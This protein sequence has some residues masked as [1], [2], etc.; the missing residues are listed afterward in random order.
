MTATSTEARKI[1]TAAVRRAGQTVKQATAWIAPAWTEHRHGRNDAALQW[2]DG[3]REEANNAL[4]LI[5]GI[6]T[7]AATKHRNAAFDILENVGAIYAAVAQ[8]ADPVVQ[9]PVEGATPTE[10]P[11]P[12]REAVPVDAEVS[13]DLAQEW[14]ETVR[15]QYVDGERGLIRERVGGLDIDLAVDGGRNVW[16]ASARRDGQLVA[17]TFAPRLGEV[18]LWLIRQLD[19][20]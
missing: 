2:A 12:A 17:E 3:A 7:V 11:A 10:T 19:S 5:D 16:V 1:Q 13:E 15:R 20:Q 14:A 4:R 6:H 9:E 18:M 8:S